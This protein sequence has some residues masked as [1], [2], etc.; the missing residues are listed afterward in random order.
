M[1]TIASSKELQGSTDGVS[2]CQERLIAILREHASVIR[3]SE[4]ESRR[5]HPELADPILLDFWLRRFREL[6][7]AYAKDLEGRADR[8][9]EVVHG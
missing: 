8:L 4:Q 6:A 7:D 5:V 3:E 1:G 2:E 9:G